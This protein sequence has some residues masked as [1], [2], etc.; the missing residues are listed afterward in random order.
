[1]NVFTLISRR[2]SLVSGMYVAMITLSLTQC[3][4]PS[5]PVSEEGRSAE[6]A[7]EVSSQPVEPNAPPPILEEI[8]QGVWQSSKLD[9]LDNAPEKIQIDFRA[10]GELTLISYNRGQLQ[11][12]GTYEVKGNELTLTME[13]QE[14]DTIQTTFDGK[15]LTIIDVDNDEKVEFQKL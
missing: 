6:V 3:D 8:I 5:A 14:A 2:K 1:M 9:G 11:W 13:G 4:K 10:N 7:N 12:E 15:T